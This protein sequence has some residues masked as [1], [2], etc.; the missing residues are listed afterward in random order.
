MAFARAAVEKALIPSD[1]SS[2]VPC[3]ESD[4]HLERNW[5]E[6]HDEKGTVIGVEITNYAIPI[7][8]E[9][10]DLLVWQGYTRGFKMP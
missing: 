4:D 7:D 8:A 3:F 2:V 9:W 10:E 6:V 1:Q 5:R